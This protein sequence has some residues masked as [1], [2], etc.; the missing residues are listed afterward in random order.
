MKNYKHFLFILFTLYINYIT[1]QE[2]TKRAI[3]SFKINIE[4]DVLIPKKSQLDQNYTIGVGFGFS[5]LKLSKWAEEKIFDRFRIKY[6]KAGDDA[7]I[8]PDN[9]NVQIS[10][11]TPDSLQV[12]HPVIGD[13]PYASHISLEYNHTYLNATQH[14]AKTFGIQLFQM[15]ISGFADSLQTKIHRGMNDNNTHD[16]YFP[17]GWPNQISNSKYGEF[18]PMVYRLKQKLVTVAALTK[19]VNSHKDSSCKKLRV[20]IVKNWSYYAGYLTQIGA[21]FNIRFGKLDLSNW[22]TDLFNNFLAIAQFSETN[23]AKYYKQKKHSELYLFLS[24]NAFLTAYNASLHGGLKP[25]IYRLDYNETGFINAQFRLGFASTSIHHAVSIYAAG[26]TPE[27]YN[28]HSRMHY[29]IGG[30]FGIK[31]P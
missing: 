24:G 23:I 20:Q 26:K 30:S 31:F 9:I 7:F 17:R 18:M 3:N 29:W 4:E 5:S 1:S 8:L 10:G 14:W 27:F 6:K 21:G 16:P 15:G 22:H 13:R 19:E 11:F 25:T 2:V 28:S 12:Y